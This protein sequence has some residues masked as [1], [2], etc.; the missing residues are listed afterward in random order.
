MIYG[1]LKKLRLN[2]NVALEHYKKAESISNK[3]EFR[4]HLPEIYELIITI[5][6]DEGKW[7]ECTKYYSLHTALSKEL[8]DIKVKNQLE[9]MTFQNELTKKSLEIELV[10]EERDLATKN[11]LLNEEISNYSAK[12][13]AFLIISILLII[14]IILFGL[15]R[16]KKE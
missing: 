5:L 11:S 7:K 14:G 9:D 4:I 6:K 2:S 16:L 12:I 3:N 15:N 8:N 10:Q 1:K 13:T